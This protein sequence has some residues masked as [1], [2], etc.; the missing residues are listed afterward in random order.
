[1]DTV[2]RIARIFH[3]ALNVAVPS[4]TTDII[5]AGILDSLG[6]VTLLVEIEEQFA[7]TIPLDEIDVDGLRTVERIAA[8]VDHLGTDGEPAPRL[9]GRMSA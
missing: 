9:P 2:D 7:V 3:D 1:M 5:A 8:L 6:L 4:A